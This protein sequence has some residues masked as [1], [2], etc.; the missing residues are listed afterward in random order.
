MSTDPGAIPAKIS[1]DSNETVAALLDTQ[2]TAPHEDFICKPWP[3]AESK[4]YSLLSPRQKRSPVWKCSTACTNVSVCSSNICPS[5][6][7]FSVAFSV[8]RLVSFG[9]FVDDLLRQKI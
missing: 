4:E 5:E 2:K 7:V 8:L 1:A 9:S 6:R 3:G